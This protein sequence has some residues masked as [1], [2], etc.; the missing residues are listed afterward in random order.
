MRNL[1]TVI[2]AVAMAACGRESPKAA[3]TPSAADTP[4]AHATTMARIDKIATAGDP[5]SPGALASLSNRLQ[6]EATHR[7]PAAAPRAE[8]VLAALARSGIALA[9]QK[10]YVARTVRA[11]YC[12]GG[13]TADGLGVSVCEYASPA[14]AAAG[15]TYVTDRFRIPDLERVIH[16]RGATTLA[17]S[18]HSGASLD[19][20]TRRAADAFLTM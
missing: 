13:Q 6:Y 16:V 15:R 2:I 10:Q 11:A 18:H 4:P 7:P 9:E 20:A 3:P 1:T 19:E 8:D 14:D 5:L 12:V 17:L